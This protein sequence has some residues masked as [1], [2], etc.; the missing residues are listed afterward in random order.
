MLGPHGKVELPQG[1][2]RSKMREAGY[3]LG[4]A[5]ETGWCMRPK[6]R[7]R[8][9]KGRRLKIGKSAVSF[10]VVLPP[11][12]TRPST[13]LGT[14]LVGC[15]CSLN[16]VLHTGPLPTHPLL[17]SRPL[18]AGARAVGWAW[19]EREGGSLSGQRDPVP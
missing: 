17:R 8:V 10:T 11:L 3:H 1:G 9:I 12:P 2:K 14:E 7:V 19:G 4:V 5:G 6:F 13:V 18:Q 15:K 16:R